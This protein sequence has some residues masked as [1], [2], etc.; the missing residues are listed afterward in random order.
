MAKRELT[1]EE[2]RELAGEHHMGPA[3]QTL[4]LAASTFP[5]GNPPGVK[6]LFERAHALI[7]TSEQYAWSLA[8]VLAGMDSDVSIKLPVTIR[9][10]ELEESSQRGIVYFHS[11]M[12]EYKD[13]ETHEESARTERVDNPEGNRVFQIAQSL[14]GKKAHLWKYTLKVD[15][16]KKVNMV[17]NIV[18]D[19]RSQRDNSATSVSTPSA[20]VVEQTQPE[21]KPET[22]EVVVPEA[23]SPSTSTSSE[24]VTNGKELIQHGQALGYSKDEIK[25]KMTEIC[26]EITDEGRTV[27]QYQ[28]VA[29]VLTHEKEHGPVKEERALNSDSIEGAYNE[30]YI[31]LNSMLQ[32]LLELGM[33]KEEVTEVGKSV[34]PPKEKN[35]KRTPVQVQAV[36]L[37]CLDALNNELS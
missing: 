13:D 7:A 35:Q 4:M 11:A 1:K 5:N 3:K 18:P 12:G 30:T 14:V 37:K 2:L 36:Y 17:A 32:R 15:G 33:D 31:D 24:V 29:N 23:P 22:V 9:K 26:G 6:A 25:E 21:P 28:A 19:A 10:V 16:S 27:E 34:L 20:P 8:Q